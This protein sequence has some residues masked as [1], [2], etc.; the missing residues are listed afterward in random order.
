M[1]RAQIIDLHPIVPFSFGRLAETEDFKQVGLLLEGLGRTRNVRHEA[2]YDAWLRNQSQLLAG[3]FHLCAGRVRAEN[4]WAG[5]LACAL[6]VTGQDRR[7][8][9]ADLADGFRGDDR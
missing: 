9:R 5:L 3:P 7:V 4:V 8:G 1:W 2:S 6:K